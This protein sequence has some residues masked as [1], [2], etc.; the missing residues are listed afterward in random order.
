MQYVL[1]ITYQR[2]IFNKREIDLSKP[3]A[4]YAPQQTEAS[5]CVDSRLPDNYSASLSQ[6]SKI[7]KKEK[8]TQMQSSLKHQNGKM[9][10]PSPT[11]RF[12]LHKSINQGDKK[13]SNI[14]TPKQSSSLK[15]SQNNDTIFPDDCHENESNDVAA[16]FKIKPDESVFDM[17][18][19]KKIL[20]DDNTQAA[21][22]RLN[23]ES[24]ESNFNKLLGPPKVMAIYENRC[25]L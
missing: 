21:G 3:S 8:T 7:N 14:Y 1:A 13:P 5:D 22:E 18:D 11:F 15:E 16:K 10:S 25:D 20:T 9:F 17:Y 4:P 23:F 24:I 2:E 12:D 19:S 6:N